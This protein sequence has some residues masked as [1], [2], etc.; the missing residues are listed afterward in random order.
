[1][2]EWI[3]HYLIGRKQQ[4]QINESCSNWREVTSGIPQGSVIGPVLFVIYI[5]DLPEIVK[6]SAYLFADDTKI[7]KTIMDDSDKQ[8]LQGDLENLTEWS[9]TWLLRFHPDKCKYLHVGKE[10][11]SEINYTLMGRPLGRVDK[12]KDIGVTVDDKL[13]F[14]QHINEKVN[15]ANSMFAIIRR[16]FQFLDKKTFIPLYKALVRSHLEYANAVWCP[17]KEKHIELVESVQRR[18]TKQI[19]GLG[20]LSYEQRLRELNLPTLKFRRYRGDMIEMFKIANGYY[21]PQ[22]TD[23]IK[24][25]R[26]Y[27]QREASRGNKSKLLIQRPRLDIRKY[28]F[29]VRVAAVWNS[30]PDSV[31]TAK[32]VNTFKNRLDRLWN[33]QEVKFDYKCEIE[34]RT[35]TNVAHQSQEALESDEEDPSGTCVGNQQ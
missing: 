29:T 5:N 20:N 13:S 28:S 17:Y 6:S 9:N 11:N 14:D 22:I 27:I 8:V 15:K 16:T 31:V 19:P 23:F 35:G 21:D 34:C 1:M 33:N 24:W 26:S 7:F 3:T 4:V 10:T 32:N 12:E 18:A 2:I 30:L 25:R